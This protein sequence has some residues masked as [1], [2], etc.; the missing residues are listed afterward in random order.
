[1]HVFVLWLLSFLTVAGASLVTIAGG[2]PGDANGVG[3]NAGFTAPTGVS[4]N[5]AGTTI[6]VVSLIGFYLV[7]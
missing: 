7:C 1:M 2:G 5:Y 4:V 3:T 6:I